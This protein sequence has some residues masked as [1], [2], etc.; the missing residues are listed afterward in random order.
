MSKIGLHK[1]I[2]KDL[3]FFKHTLNTSN[4]DLK[5]QLF[6]HIVIKKRHKTK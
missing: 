1:K 2:Q 6:V 3:V 5:L 4:T